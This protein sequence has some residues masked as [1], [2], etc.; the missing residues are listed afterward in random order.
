[1]HRVSVMQ[2]HQHIFREQFRIYYNRMKNGNNNTVKGIC[3]IAGGLISEKQGR[4]NTLK[5]LM[6][7]IGVE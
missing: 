4:W 5:R 6:Y 7:R 2:D 1:M 3:T